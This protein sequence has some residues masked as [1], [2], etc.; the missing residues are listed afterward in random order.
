V[1]PGTNAMIYKIFYQKKTFPQNTACLR[2]NNHNVGLKNA[3]FSPKMAENSD[4]N[5][6]PWNQSHDFLS[7]LGQ[8]FRSILHQMRLRFAEL[9]VS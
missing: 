1:G 2:R 6:D 4:H 8:I 7:F 5:I 3:T 9:W